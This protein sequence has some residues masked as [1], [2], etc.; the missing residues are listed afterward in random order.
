MLREETMS[1]VRIVFFGTP[2]FATESLEK[3][4]KE[5]SVVGVVT[6]Q[7]KPVGRAQLLSASPVKLLAQSLHLKVFQPPSLQKKTMSGKEFLQVFRNLMPDI[8]VV[9]AYGK[10]IPKE[11][12]Q[13][14]R[15]GFIN[16]H[17]SVL[18]KLRGASPIQ[19]AILEGFKTSGVTIMQLD[20]GM[21]TGDIL[22]TE[23][24][25]IT[26][27]ETSESLHNRLK[28]IG[29]ELLVKT[30][31]NLIDGSVTPRKQNEKEAT[32]CTLIKKTDGEIDWSQSPEHI[33]RKIRA[34]NPW[35]GAYTFCNKKRI[36]ILSATVNNAQQLVIQI[37]Q[38]EG[39]KPMPYSEFIKGYPHCPLPPH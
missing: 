33:E 30:I 23:E 32:F 15:Y 39:K 7:D 27:N 24:I 18:P 11:F 35:P 10:I 5:F 37:V 2:V 9:V 20:E 13:I 38:P 36:R 6:Q 16:V 34:L 25:N 19:T 17:P 4:H 31:W 8:A 26:P 3:L 21:D 22:S 29:A 28:T 12:L 1:A 14:P